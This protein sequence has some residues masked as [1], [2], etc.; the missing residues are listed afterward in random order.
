M[1]RHALQELELENNIL[2][3]EERWLQE[4]LSKIKTQKMSLEVNNITILS[5]TIRKSF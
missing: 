1:S 5:I 3:E 4:A 2:A